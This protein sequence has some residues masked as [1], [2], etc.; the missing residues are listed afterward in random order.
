MVEKQQ[1]PQ[2]E[3]P[4]ETEQVIKSCASNIMEAASRIL[5]LRD[6]RGFSQALQT[7]KLNVAR[8]ESLAHKEP[9]G[10]VIQGRG[11]SPDAEQ[12]VERERDWLKP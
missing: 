5:E 3:R 1:S 10:P 4:D 6:P 9:L 8:L 2:S 12:G 11:V 7:I